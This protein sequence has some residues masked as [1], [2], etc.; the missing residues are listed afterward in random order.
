M[1]EEIIIQTKLELCFLSKACWFSVY[2]VS[3]SLMDINSRQ[4]RTPKDIF[5]GDLLLNSSQASNQSFAEV[6]ILLV[7]NVVSLYAV[8]YP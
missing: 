5:S 2:Q 6:V 4:N 3:E 7:C 8:K 1:E